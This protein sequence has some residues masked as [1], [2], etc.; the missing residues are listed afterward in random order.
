MGDDIDH[1]HETCVKYIELSSSRLDSIVVILSEL[2]H[3]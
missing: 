2:I 3:Y 1:N